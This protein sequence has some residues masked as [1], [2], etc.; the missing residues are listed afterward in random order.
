MNWR[1]PDGSL[2]RQC[3]RSAFLLAFLANQSVQGAADRHLTGREI[4]RQHCAKCHGRNGEGVKGKFEGPLQGER[5]LEKLIRYIE[6]NMPDDNP[7]KIVGPDATAVA[8]H[9]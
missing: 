6:R 3:G 2:I 1:I 9:I 8:R 4:F 5:S 7:G